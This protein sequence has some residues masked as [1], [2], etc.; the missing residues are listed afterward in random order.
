MLE[1]KIISQALI[2]IWVFPFQTLFRSYRGEA[3]KRSS[4][5]HSSVETQSRLFK[6]EFTFTCVVFTSV[7]SYKVIVRY[8]A[9]RENIFGTVH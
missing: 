1:A 6:I 9:V 2:G 5:D 7:P 3:V 4:V 8:S